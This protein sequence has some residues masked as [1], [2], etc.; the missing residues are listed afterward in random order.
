MEKTN[1]KHKFNAV[2]ALL[3]IL[4]LA[5]IGAAAFFLIISSGVLSKGDGDGKITLEYEVEFR[6]VR[7][8]FSEIILERWKE[9]DKVTDASMGDEIGELVSVRVEDAVFFG[10]DMT[11]EGGKL[12]AYDYPNHCNITMVIR[13]TAGIGEFERYVLDEDYDLSVGSAVYVRLPYFTYTGYCT[14]I[15]ELKETVQTEAE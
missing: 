1:K 13:T 10:N 6:T 5:I 2:D 11:G 14:R 12:V 7:N 3:L 9:G 4:I 8:E 15:Q